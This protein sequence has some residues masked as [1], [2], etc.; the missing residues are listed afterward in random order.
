MSKSYDN[1]IELF[2]SPKKLKK[3]VGRIVTDSSGVEEPKEPEENLIYRLYTCVATDEEREVMAARFREGGY[4]YGDAKKELLGKLLEYFAPARE[5]REELAKDRSY[6]DG[7]LEARG[8]SSE[9][10]RRSACAN[11]RRARCGLHR[12]RYAARR[13]QPPVLLARVAWCSDP[14]VVRAFQFGCPGSDAS[15]LD[16]YLLFNLRS[17]GAL[18][19]RGWSQVCRNWRRMS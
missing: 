8:P 11:T 12:G 13:G 14:T 5:R 4:G 18:T 15:T 6:V 16:V 10:T 19:D 7:V 3:D 17:S 9:S 1:A 2:A